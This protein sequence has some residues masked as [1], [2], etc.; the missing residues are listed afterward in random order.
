MMGYILRKSIRWFYPWAKLEYVYTTKI[1]VMSPGSIILSN[2]SD[3]WTVDEYNIILYH[4]T[5]VSSYRFYQCNCCLIGLKCTEEFTENATLWN[6]SIC[7][8]K[9]CSLS[10]VKDKRWWGKLLAISLIQPSVKWHIFRSRVW[11]LLFFWQLWKPWIHM[12]SFACMYIYMNIIWI[13]VCWIYI[14]MHA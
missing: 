4:M 8:G 2:Q 3:M 12:K 1:T 5:A 10:F 14:Y 7:S 9:I 6:P 11:N 13:N